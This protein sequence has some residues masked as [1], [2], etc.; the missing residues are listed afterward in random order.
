MKS[1]PAES[2]YYPTS[3]IL[4]WNEQQGREKAPCGRLTLRMDDFESNPSVNY[5][6]LV[7]FP[8]FG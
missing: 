2:P 7:L 6:M 3:S 4:R 8:M 5:G 1:K